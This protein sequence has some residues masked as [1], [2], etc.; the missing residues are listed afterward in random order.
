M[1]DEQI[2]DKEM[3]TLKLIFFSM[4][5]SLA[6]YLYVGLAV[7]K[8]PQAAIDN[9][10][11]GTLRAALYCMAFVILL[12]TKPVRKFLLGKRSWGLQQTGSAQHPVIQ[13]YVQALIIASGM[14]ECIGIFGLV[15]YI[16]GK[17][18]LDLY[19]LIAVSA[20]AMLRYRPNRAEVMRLIDENQGGPQL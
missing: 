8:N 14:T 5:F 15:L 6:V 1:I 17:N 19:V 20:I 16:K 18:V 2:L 4:V 9:E 12:I 13:K 11:L 10:A 3:K 7:V